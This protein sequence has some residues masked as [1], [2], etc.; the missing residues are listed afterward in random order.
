[1]SVRLALSNTPLRG[2]DR[3]ENRHERMNFHLS[4]FEKI[5]RAS[6]RVERLN[7]KKIYIISGAAR[8][9][10]GNDNENIRRGNKT[11]EGGNEG[12]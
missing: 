9:A 3:D 10:S 11:G 6:Y 1:M 2:I 7:L 4:R 5:S 8:R 12:G